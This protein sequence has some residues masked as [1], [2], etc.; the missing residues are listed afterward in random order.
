VTDPIRRRND[1]PRL[2]EEGATYFVTWCL[3]R[4]APPLTDDE[5]TVVADCLQHFDGV[6]YHLDAWLVMDDHIH[7]VVAPLEGR[8][9]DSLLHSWRSFVAHTL[10]KRGR[11]VPMWRRDEHDR[12]VHA[13]G[14]LAEKVA[15]VAGNPWRRWPD[16]AQYPWVFPQPEP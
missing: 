13:D 10:A 7:V 2:R 6:R 12:I 9:L 3:A 1:R 8:S 5:R 16:A 11:Q 15:Y 4:G 14:E